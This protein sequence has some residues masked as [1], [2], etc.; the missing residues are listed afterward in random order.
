[1][2]VGDAAAV[3]ADNE[4]GPPREATARNTKEASGEKKGLRLDGLADFGSI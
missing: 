2:A 3:G 1:V 4:T